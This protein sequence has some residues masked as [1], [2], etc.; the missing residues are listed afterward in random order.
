LIEAASLEHHSCASPKQPNQLLSLALGAN[1]QW[2][3]SD[4][5]EM[6]KA[7]LAG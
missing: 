6:L 3:V 2:V 5:L 4:L 7:M 1:G